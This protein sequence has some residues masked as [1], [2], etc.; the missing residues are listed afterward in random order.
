MVNGTP[1]GKN[2]SL[3]TKHMGHE[4]QSDVDDGT[5]LTSSVGVSKDPSYAIVREFGKR[6]VLNPKLIVYEI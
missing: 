1:R 6:R 4:E 5:N 3:V 2:T